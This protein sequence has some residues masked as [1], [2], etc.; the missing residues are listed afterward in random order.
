MQSGCSMAGCARRVGQRTRCF[1]CSPSKHCVAGRFATCTS[2]LLHIPSR[3]C[4]RL[5]SGDVGF[6]RF[7]SRTHLTISG[8]FGT[9][10]CEQDSAGWMVGLCRNTR[11]SANW[12][13]AGA[14]NRLYC[15]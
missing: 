8:R 11:R 5:C 14:G 2:P 3:L 1:Q 10:D 13:A 6:S 7:M 4:Y 15:N 9:F 12:Q